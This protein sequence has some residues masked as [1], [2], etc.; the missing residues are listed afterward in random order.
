MISETPAYLNNTGIRRQ[1]LAWSDWPA[2]VA[3]LKDELICRIAVNDGN[4]P[5]VSAL[6]YTFIRNEFLLHSSRHGRLASLLRAE[7]VIT[8]EVDRPVALLK[9]PKGQNTSL[10]YYSVLAKCRTNFRE[11]AKDVVEHQMAAL[12]KFR[13]ENDYLPIEQGAAEQIVAYRCEV[14]EM[15]AKKRILADGQYSPPGQPKAPYLRFPF[16]PGACINGLGH[17]AFDSMRFRAP[18]RT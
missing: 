4:A 9:A 12:G 11:V 2:I 10:E 8:I 17:D 16:P 14:L 1:D 7:P 6:S 3:F 15:T 18:A 5:Y 13:P